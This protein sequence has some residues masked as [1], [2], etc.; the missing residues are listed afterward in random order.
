M[1]L[2]F[3]FLML[4]S[5]CSSTTYWKDYL[6]SIVFPLILCQGSV[7]YIFVGLISGLSSVPWITLYVLWPLPHCLDYCSF[8]VNLEVRWCQSS[9]FVL[10]Y[11]VHCSG[12][13]ACS[14]KLWDHGVYNH[15]APAGTLTGTAL[16]L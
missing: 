13:L 16:N 5:S 1:F 10:Q 8:V 7:V 12:F 11:C 9:N 14:Y 4:K 6:C 2:F 3:F 15:R